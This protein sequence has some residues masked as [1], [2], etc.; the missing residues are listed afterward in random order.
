MS[1]EAMDIMMNMQR[2]AWRE[3]QPIH[4]KLKDKPIEYD[5]SAIYDNPTEYMTT[6]GIFGY[7]G[8][9]MIK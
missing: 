8:V 3:R 5:T 9:E 4:Y 6:K 7:T 1:K 2:D